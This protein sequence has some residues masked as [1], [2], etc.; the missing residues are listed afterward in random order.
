MSNPPTPERPPALDSALVQQFVIA[1]HGNL[2]AVQTLL[3]DTPALLNAA[4]DWGGGDWETALGGAAHVGNVA[5]AR[6]LLSHGARMDIFA[7]AMLGELDLV[8]AFLAAHPDALHSAG[9]HGIPLLTHAQMGVRNGHTPAQAVV[10]YLTTRL[11]E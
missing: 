10:D 5:I 3:A 7:A 6:F 8:K 4:W 1:G 9:P 2:A 11:A